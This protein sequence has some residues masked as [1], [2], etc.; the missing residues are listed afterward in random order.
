MVCP[1]SHT[2]M[3]N[4]YNVSFII[5]TAEH[6]VEC[7]SAEKLISGTWFT[8]PK[9]NSQNKQKMTKAKAGIGTTAKSSVRGRLVPIGL[10]DGRI[11]V[12]VRLSGVFRPWASNSFLEP[13][14]TAQIYSCWPPSAPLSLPTIIVL[15]PQ[16]YFLSLYIHSND[17]PIVFSVF[18]FPMFFFFLFTNF[19]TWNKVIFM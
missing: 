1:A 4:V 2:H 8:E 19:F 6:Y 5:W 17:S 3:N 13:L 16:L 9:I 15:F 14:R 12:A 10:I 7:Q 11:Y 18:S